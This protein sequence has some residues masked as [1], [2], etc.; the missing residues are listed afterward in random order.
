[1]RFQS[2][3]QITF[4]LPVPIGAVLHLT[5]KVVKTTR[6]NQGRDGEAKAHIQVKAEVEE[7]ETGVS[8]FQLPSGRGIGADLA[9]EKRNQHLLLYHGQGRFGAYWADGCSQDI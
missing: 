1:M 4:L 9:A 3:D 5:S 8:V 7:V 2:L 6:P